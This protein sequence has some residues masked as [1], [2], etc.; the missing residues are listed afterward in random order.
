MSLQPDYYRDAPHFR[1]VGAGP[2]YRLEIPYAKLDYT[3]AYSVIAKNCHGEA[4][5]IISLQIYA[6]GQG[7]ADTSMEQTTIKHGYGCRFESFKCSLEKFF[8]SLYYDDVKCR[9][10]FCECERNSYNQPIIFFKAWYTFPDEKK[11][12]DPLL[13]NTE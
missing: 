9:R 5:A 3:G 8:M 4:K 11:L 2:Q 7:K 10:T 12:L 13:I 6:R 1:R